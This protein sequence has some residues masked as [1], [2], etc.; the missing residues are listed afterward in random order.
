MKALSDPGRVVVIKLLGRRDLCVCE[1]TAL[2]GLAQPTVSK[3]LRVLEE[4][5]LVTRKKE[6][7]WINF[8]L[9]DGSDSP[10]A[11]ALLGHLGAW[12]EEDPGLQ[13][14][15]A[16]LPQVDRQQLKA[17]PPRKP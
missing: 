11:T 10:Y 9:A 17:C 1:I 7:P 3:H 12:L 16:R 14:I 5:G 13:E 15:L 8:H 2:L 4:A 6:G